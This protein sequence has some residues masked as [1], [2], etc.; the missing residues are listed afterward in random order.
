[1]TR[2]QFLSAAT[3]IKALPGYKY[4]FPRDHFSHPEFQ[5]E[6]WYYT[7]NLATQSGRRFGYELT[8]FRAALQPSIEQKSIWSTRDAYMAHLALTDVE[9]KQFF[10]AERLNRPGPGLAGVDLKSERIWNGNW[11]CHLTPNKHTLL[12][13]DQNFNI[14][15]ALIPAKPHVIH[16]PN[17]VS[18]KGPNPG[19][20]SHYIS[21]PRL[22]TQGQIQLSG[23]T[24]QVQGNTWMDHEYFS[25]E[26]DQNLAGWDWFSIQLDNSTELMLYRLRQ[27]DGKS[28]PFSAGTFINEKGQTTHLALS[29]IQFTPQR[30]WKR[31]PVEWLIRIPSIGIE[32]SAKPLLDNQELLS[33]SKLTPSY[34]EGAMQFTGSQSGR[35]YLEMTGYDDRVR[36]MPR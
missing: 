19:Q 10:H 17:G 23:I 11:S 29:D 25:S 14:N 4:E 7:G 13:T 32:L 33:K 24:H 36:F 3:F 5:T 8:F 34:W 21:F 35:G 6:W 9:G 22:T 27:K 28:S 31:Y 26:L 18:Q 20:A 30:L 1:M 2:R 12:A 15:L 16:G